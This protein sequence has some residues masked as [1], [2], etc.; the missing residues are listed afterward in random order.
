MVLKCMEE[1]VKCRCELLPQT[2]LLWVPADPCCCHR[3]CHLSP[4]AEDGLLPL[5]QH[6]QLIEHPVALLKTS[7][8]SFAQSREPPCLSVAHRGSN[9]LCVLC[10]FAPLL[11][12]NCEIKAQTQISLAH[13]PAR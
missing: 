11:W 7:G 4:P 12:P 1:F 6:P 13:F 2:L 5:L 9:V 3:C 8:S 10:M